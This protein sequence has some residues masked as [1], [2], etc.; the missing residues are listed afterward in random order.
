M[1]DF[2]N[3]V[4][5]KSCPLGQGVDVP[6]GAAVD[7]TCVLCAG[8]TF[9]D[10]ASPTE[11]CK[12]HATCP[13]GSGLSKAGTPESDLECAACTDVFGKQWFSDE[14]SRNACTFPTSCP[15]GY[16]VGVRSTSSTN[17]VCVPCEGGTFKPAP[18]DFSNTCTVYSG[19]GIGETH[20]QDA[21]FAARTEDVT[22]EACAAGM[23]KPAP[24]IPLPNPNGNM[25]V[26]SPHLL[27]P[28]GVGHF[29]STPA[30]A[31]HDVVC[32]VCPADTYKSIHS[33]GVCGAC[34]AACDALTETEKTPCT[35]GAGSTNRECSAREVCKATDGYNT[36]T[37]LTPCTPYSTCPKCTGV[38]TAG[39]DKSDRTCEACPARHFS[40]ADDDQPC[41]AQTRCAAGMGLITPCTTSPTT[42]GGTNGCASATWSTGEP[43][44]Q[45]C[46]N[47]GQ[48][49]EPW[50]KEC[51]KW[52]GSTADGS[53]VGL[54]DPCKD[55][56]CKACPSGFFS[57]SLSYDECK[58]W[59]KAPV[60]QGVFTAG[61]ATTDTVVSD[62]M[63]T[64]LGGS[65][66]YSDVEDYGP[67]KD[68]TTCPVGQ[69]RV[70][71]DGMSKTEDVVCATCPEGYFSATDDRAPCTPFTP[72]SVGEGIDI[73]GTAFKDATCV[74]CGG[75]QFKSTVD[76]ELCAIHSLCKVG[77]GSVVTGDAV[78]DTICEVCNASTTATTSGGIT[79]FEGTYSSTESLDSCVPLSTCNIGFGLSEAGTN[80]V[81]TKCE[82][83]AS[84][85][86]SAAKDHSP[87]SVL[88]KCGVSEGEAEKGTAN[89]DT[90]CLVC[91]EGSFSAVES[92]DACEAWATCPVGSGLATIGTASVDRFCL[93]CG[94]G[95]YSDVDD[96]SACK[97]FTTSAIG[98]GQ[99]TA[100]NATHDAVS[101]A[102]GNGTFSN[103]DDLTSCKPWQTCGLG[104]GVLSSG[105]GA[106]DVICENCVLDTSGSANDGK[107]SD[108]DD[109]V[110]VC[111]LL[112][113]CNLGFGV[114]PAWDLWVQDKQVCPTDQTACSN[115]CG[116][117]GGFKSFSAPDKCT[118]NSDAA[119]SSGARPNA[120]QVSKDRDC[121]PCDG[122]STFSAKHDALACAAFGS[123]PIGSGM[124]TPGSATADVVCG[125]CA[126]G[127]W[128]GVDDRSPC[129]PCA[130]ACT[131]ANGEKESV[132]CTTAT[133]RVCVARDV[134]VNATWS[135]TGRT[136]CDKTHSTCPVGSGLVKLG[137]ELVDT[138][139]AACVDGTYSDNDDKFPCIDIGRCTVGTGVKTN[140][141][142]SSPVECEACATG[143]FNA[144]PG[145]EACQP[146]SSC[147]VGNGVSRAP[148]AGWDV[149]CETCNNGVD[150]FSA[151]DSLD[152]CQAHAKCGVGE[153]FKTAGNATHDTVCVPCVAGGTGSFSDTTSLDAC[154][155][156]TS[157][158]LG[159]GVQT[160]ATPATDTICEKCREGSFSDVVDAT[161][162]C[163]MR[164]W[165]G[166]GLGAFPSSI[167][168]TSETI[169]N[170]CEDKYFSDLNN[171]GDCQPHKICP[172][173]SGVTSLGNST[174]D[175]VCE[176][177]PATIIE[178]N[179][180]ETGT[181]TV[182]GSFNAADD[183][184]HCRKHAL[185]AVGSGLDALGT[186]T[187]DTKCSPCLDGAYSSVED[188]TPCAT[189]S[190][191]PM[192]SGLIV[193]G[194]ASA[195]T[196]CSPCPNATFSPVD[197]LSEC[198]EVAT[199][200]VGQGETSAPNA[201]TDR[202]CAACD[203]GL[204][205][206][207]DDT[208]PCQ[209]CHRASAL[210][211]CNATDKVAVECSASTDRVCVP[212]DACIN[213]SWSATGLEPCD[214]THSN[215]SI[216]YG[217][218]ICFCMRYLNA[219]L[220]HGYT[221]GGSVCRLSL[222]LVNISLFFS[223]TRQ[224]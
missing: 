22:C 169:C 106:I 180:G 148:G 30:D 163:A 172:Q 120:M 19:C 137:T 14:D 133:D 75:G 57:P 96:G 63:G 145:L 62:C 83:C 195:N 18:A 204:F 183:L 89:S 114:D 28:C 107:F 40:L 64:G 151:V 51:C 93:A 124:Q 49:T 217:A 209:P 24:G 220:A 5:H 69:G 214:Q 99:T 11:T 152:T 187:V 117:K 159:E 157:C 10:V 36:V 38:D 203:T 20:K 202:V 94:A 90:R 181:T 84:G 215:C 43:S 112:S 166:P 29:N 45:W 25:D 165:C 1:D 73:N 154:Q 193:V 86:F 98:H 143:S 129:S 12:T 176:L 147:G 110:S 142:A 186:S 199:C 76:L 7:N 197:D 111:R 141:T 123:C 17:T 95:Y 127:Q 113:T 70:V 138:E 155:A 156:P 3:C 74:A 207:L 153:G 65:T 134:C 218:S 104:R 92:Y 126:P 56:V 67:C 196:Q 100:G 101:E 37:G 149:V 119:C 174:H 15:A 192:G 168:P 128:S 66:A 53:C 132:E 146:W 222:F 97:P 178:E 48:G 223:A 167:S 2:S 60:G 150:T 210:L 27:N 33:W 108:V 121:L 130:A 31:T 35:Q 61:S 39:T 175:T 77:S 200:P 216:G 144:K 85:F 21:A 158:P 118:C 201:T 194:S 91:P 41:V 72:C 198:L 26:C 4:P 46:T 42:H 190:T 212:R 211:P 139:C 80:A 122:V 182:I 135:D 32:D 58:P 54:D 224:L 219:I 50:F 34:A 13:K 177:C 140:G 59:T 55:T 115:W 87:C 47:T 23:F 6:G 105:T 221:Y 103:V 205:S 161:S 191:C 160:Q 8:D 82:A 71:G 206:A 9:S 131:I 52:V 102:C 185:C 184:S 44:K 109:Y 68:F 164:M 162:R 78:R 189:W 188:L 173:A 125:M 116:T 208:A 179:V 171:L 170:V 213:V 16:R 79:V 81:D 88:S 136:P